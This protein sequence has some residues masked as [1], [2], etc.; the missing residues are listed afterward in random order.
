MQ[1]SLGCVRK[2]RKNIQIRKE[3]TRT[4]AGFRL[5]KKKKRGNTRECGGGSSGHAK[6]GRLITMYT[7]SCGEKKLEILHSSQ[8]GEQGKKIRLGTKNP[9]SI[10]SEEGREKDLSAEFSFALRQEK[11]IRGPP[12]SPEFRGGK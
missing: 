1:S 7:S 3:E 9:K 8:R 2:E 10:G 11:K 5:K 12:Q 6:C 4:T